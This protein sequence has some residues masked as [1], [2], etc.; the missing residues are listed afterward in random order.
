MIRKDD[1]WVIGK[2]EWQV[3]WI[4][5][6]GWLG[7]RMII[8]TGLRE[9]AVDGRGTLLA[10]FA[11]PLAWTPTPSLKEKESQPKP[12]TFLLHCNDGRLVPP[13][14]WKGTAGYHWL[15]C[16]IKGYKDKHQRIGIVGSKTK[17]KNT[18]RQTRHGKV[19]FKES[20]G[21]IPFQMTYCFYT[22]LSFQFY[23]NLL[24]EVFFECKILRKLIFSKEKIL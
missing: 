23:P 22:L 5:C 24:L 7:R 1:T 18:T 9:E 21:Q 11:C 8:S 3:K 15:T 17:F 16:Q 10:S 14:F 20:F 19:K 6:F 4:Y 13:L 2:R 12:R